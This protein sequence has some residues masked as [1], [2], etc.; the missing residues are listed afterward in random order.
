MKLCPRDDETGSLRAGLEASADA[1]RA[2]IVRRLATAPGVR[3]DRVVHHLDGIER[4]VWPQTLVDVGARL[5]H[6]WRSS[7]DFQPPDLL[8][9]LDA[10]GFVPTIAVS[11]ASGAPYQLAWKLD[12]DIPNK[13]MF[14][15]LHASRPEVFFYGLAACRRVLIIDDEVTTGRTAASLAEV[16][17]N[18]GADAVG[19]LCLVEEAS[20]YGRLNLRHA[21]VPL[22]ALTTI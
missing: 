6:K 12:L 22:C 11:L 18:A 2:R 15:E 7:P 21:G 13:R 1:Y 4:E 14:R 3:S 16:L 17:R 8:V 20:R 19:V 5:W 9:G 10:G